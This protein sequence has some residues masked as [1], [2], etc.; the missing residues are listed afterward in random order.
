VKSTRKSWQEGIRQY[1]T[2]QRKRGNSRIQPAT[3]G[4][5][6]DYTENGNA[7]RIE[8]DYPRRASQTVHNLIGH[9]WPDHG[10]AGRAYEQHKQRG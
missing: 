3:K 9:E 10:N 7:T 1:Y 4:L 2:D 5:V 6:A 8:G